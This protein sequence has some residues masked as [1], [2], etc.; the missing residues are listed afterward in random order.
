MPRSSRSRAILATAVVALIL[1][2]TAAGF[3]AG[4]TF[5]VRRGDSADFHPGTWRCLYPKQGPVDCFSGDARP[6]VKIGIQH[7]C[8]CVALKVYN[9]GSA[10]RPTRA[11]ERGSAVYT[12]I[13]R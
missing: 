6:Y 5:T 11:V 12:F 7:S 1:A 4:R 3:S 13:A 9:Y 8:G 2:G 10:P